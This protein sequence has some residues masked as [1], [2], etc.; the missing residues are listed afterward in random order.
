MVH[1]LLNVTQ[2]L[3]SFDNF[4]GTSL[5]CIPKMA[6]NFKDTTMTQELLLL[7][8]EPIFPKII[9]AD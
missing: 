6:N 3:L 1:Q 5:V 4:E 8:S 2:L 9:P 7:V